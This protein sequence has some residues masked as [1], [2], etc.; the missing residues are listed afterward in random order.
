MARKNREGMVRMSQREITDP[1]IV[2]RKNTSGAHELSDKSL[3]SSS[4][5]NLR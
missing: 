5:R 1:V 3:L 2:Y 4:H